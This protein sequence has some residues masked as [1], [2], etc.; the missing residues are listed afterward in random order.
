M[1]LVLYLW[2]S[3]IFRLALLS[4]NQAEV[5]V[6]WCPALG[7]VLANE[8]VIDGVSERGGHPVIRKPMRQWMLRI[9]SYAD[10]LLEDLD[11]LDWPES[12]K[13]M[14]R[15]WIGRSEGA[16]LEFSAVDKEGHDL[17]ANLLVYTTRPD[18]IF[19]ATYVVLAPEHSLLSS[20]ISE[21]QRVHVCFFGPFSH[22]YHYH[23]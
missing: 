11:E 1:F 7:T 14:Q 21:E 10:R 18:T 16:E 23:V 4:Y 3:M 5:P 2:F 8:E 13:E 9:T 22:H 19:G 12:I 6:N 17:G 15:N 20:L